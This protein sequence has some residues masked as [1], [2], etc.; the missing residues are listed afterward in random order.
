M[1]GDEIPA[2]LGTA[3]G[4]RVRRKAREAQGFE[5]N[6]PRCL[7][8]EHLQAPKLGVPSGP[9]GK[10]HPFVPMACRLGNFQVKAW[11]ICDRWTG[12]DGETLEDS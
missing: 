11:S 1:T 2:R 5:L 9:A 10:G 3:K 4:K 8:C 6:P 12:R 7:N